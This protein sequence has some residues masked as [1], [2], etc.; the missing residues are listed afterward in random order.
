MTV[1][2]GDAP[3]WAGFA[4]S[5][6][7][8][9]IAL[10]ALKHSKDSAGASVI[11]AQAAVRQAAAAERQVELAEAAFKAAEEKAAEPAAAVDTRP[12]QE[13]LVGPTPPYVA[14]WI[15]QRSKNNYVLRNIGTDTARNVEIDKSRIECPFRGATEVE[16]LPPQAS[17]G[18][19]LIPAWGAPKPNELWVRWDEHPDW[20]AV[21]VP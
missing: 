1:D 15:E 4:I 12:A 9:V 5:L 7:A 14:W 18:L 10:R 8:S 20:V 13:V 17:L 21:P 3:A 19:L 11:S 6:G 2:W 16:E